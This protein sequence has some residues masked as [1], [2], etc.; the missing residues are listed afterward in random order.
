MNFEEFNESISTKL[1]GLSDISEKYSIFNES[2]REEL[3]LNIEKAKLYVQ[4]SNGTEDD[5]AYL[6]S[7]AEGEA[8]NKL[9][10]GLAK[11]QTATLS[12]FKSIQE[13]LS[14]FADSARAK[15]ALDKLA[16]SAELAKKN[17][18]VEISKMPERFN[19]VKSDVLSKIAVL[20]TNPA[21][22][23]TK[24]QVEKLNKE[25]AEITEQISGTKEKISCTADKLVA[26]YKEKLE[27]IKKTVEN[28][29]VI[30][31]AVDKIAEDKEK[32]EKRS[33]ENK[34]QIMM[35]VNKLS[36]LMAKQVAV[37]KAD[38]SKISSAIKGPGSEATTESVETEH[39]EIPDLLDN[40]LEEKVA[41]MMKESEEANK[42]DEYDELLATI[43]SEID[44]EEEAEKSEV[45]D[46]TLDE[47]T[48]VDD[49]V[50]ELLAEIM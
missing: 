49:I 27:C 12:T 23:L 40:I 38:V 34:A 5:L 39:V 25:I 47:S 7:E 50:E 37:I 24:E 16:N 10:E 15:L 18:S 44:Q 29:K 21:A 22:T 17:V 14:Q 36:S 31:Q 48:N 2:V 20:K 6:I 42:P 46:I 30:S 19:A 45:V 43:E 11:F 8:D 4:E 35:L 32:W 28:N 9:K 41:E 3:N 26:K 33:A 13:D 1:D